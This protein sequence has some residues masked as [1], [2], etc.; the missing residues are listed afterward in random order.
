MASADF[1][2]TPKP[3]PDL[4]IPS[5][6]NTVTVRVIDSTA[7]GKGP[8]KLVFSPRIPGHETMEF[9]CFSFLISNEAKNKHVLF[10][11]GIRKDY[12]NLAPAVASR[13]TGDNPLFKVDVEKNVADILDE[14][15][16]GVSSKDIDSVIWSHHHWVS[17]HEHGR[18]FAF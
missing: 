9:P 10:D 17:A 11:I 6:N 14:G 7:F 12:W 1:V 13:I 15:A 5:S 18:S 16:V 8:A 4:K 3:L 2:A